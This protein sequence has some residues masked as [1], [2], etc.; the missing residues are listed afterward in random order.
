MARLGRS[1]DA[2]EIGTQQ[3][4][5]AHA[6]AAYLVGIGG[7][8]ALARRADLGA[9]LGRLVRGVEHAVRGQNQVGL[10]RNAELLGEV[11]AAGRERFGLFTEKDGVDHHTVTDDIG[12]T[13]LEYARR[14]RAEH[15]F[16]AVEF[17]CMT[18]IGAALEAGYDLVAR[19]QHIHNFSLALVTPLQ[20]EDNVN[21]FHCI[22]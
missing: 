19:R 2:F 8:D 4:P 3:I 15:V 22:R 9:A 12:L 13:A 10:L 17:Q 16:L 7:T 6:V 18:G 1:V 20:A 5:Y 14:D 21:F 11:V